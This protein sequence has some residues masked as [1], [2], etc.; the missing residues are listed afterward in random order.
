[1]VVTILIG[2][3][4]ENLKNFF[5]LPAFSHPATINPKVFPVAADQEG[6]RVD[7]V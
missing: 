4:R 1:V 6:K 7:F 5:A 2:W 3:H